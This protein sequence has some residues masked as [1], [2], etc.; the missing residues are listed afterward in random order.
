MTGAFA[1]HA[2]RPAQLFG[3]VRSLL[4][5]GRGVGIGGFPSAPAASA[6]VCTL[7]DRRFERRAP[8]AGRY[9][10]LLPLL[11]PPLRSGRQ[12]TINFST[13]GGA[14]HR[15]LPSA[16]RDGVND[17]DPAKAKQPSVP[18]CGLPNQRCALG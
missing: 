12:H 15:A 14:A 17:D 4:A 2:A 13:G 6:S 11:S 16:G 1:R 10:S 18:A 5:A 3:T 8:D 9:D 7:T